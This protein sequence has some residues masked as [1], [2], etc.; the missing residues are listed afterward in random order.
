L[1][2]VHAALVKAGNQRC[3]AVLPIP[4]GIDDQRPVCPLHNIRVGGLER[5]SRQRNIYSIKTW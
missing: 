5:T 1:L 4:S 3:H 2:Q